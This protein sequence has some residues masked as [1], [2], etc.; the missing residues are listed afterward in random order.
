MVAQSGF[1]HL[2]YKG[3]ITYE[4]GFNFEI[5]YEINKRHYN[6]WSYFFSGYTRNVEREKRL[7]NWTF[8]MYYE[9]NIIAS[10]NTYLNLK[11]GTSLGTNEISFI[12]DAILGLEYNY[13]FTENTKF[14]ILFKNNIM[15]NSLVKFRHGLLIG[16]KHR[17]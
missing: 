5:G 6:N 13:A 3:G 1:N 2:T 11:I 8:G 7:N 12:M 16:F 9:P 4:Q 14:T 17:L 10:K 15:F